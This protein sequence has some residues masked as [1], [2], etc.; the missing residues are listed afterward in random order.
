VFRRGWRRRTGD[1]GSRHEHDAS[2]DFHPH[3]FDYPGLYIYVQFVVSV[4]RFMGGAVAGEWTS[5]AAAP[6]SEFYVWGRAVTATLGVATVLVVFQ[7]GMRWGAR[8]AL[9]SAGLM[10]VLPQHVRE[11]HY[12]LTDVPLTFFVALTLL[13]SLR[14]TSAGTGLPLGWRGGGLATATNTGAFA[15]HSARRLPDVDGGS[16]TPRDAVDSRFGPYDVSP[17]GAVYGARPAGISQ[18]VRTAEQRLPGRHP[19][20]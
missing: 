19:T 15:R 11:S 3:F 9:L 17:G 1:R 7:I 16:V 13:L 5:L 4:V 18:R 8:H 12:V 10:A 20:S 14:A 2:G 6:T